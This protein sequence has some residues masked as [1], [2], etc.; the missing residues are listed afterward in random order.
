MKLEL[1][2]VKRHFA[3][4]KA[5]N[6]VGIEDPSDIR[7]TFEDQ[8]P[9]FAQNIA[10]TRA[11]MHE[12]KK[13]NKSQP[14]DIT[15]DEALKL[16]YGIDFKQ[17]LKSLGIYT[18]ADKLVDVGRRFG[19][20]GLNK[21]RFEELMIDHSSFGLP[22]STQDINADYRFI[23]PEV[24]AQ[25]VRIGYQH[26]ALHPN[27]IATT[28]NLAK[29][30]LTMP[31]ILR[32]DAMPTRVNEGAN[33]PMGSLAFGKKEVE[34][35]KIGTGFSVT[36]ELMLEATLDMFFLFLQEV[37]SDMSIGADT[38]AVS[39]LV[40]G[41]Q[42]DLSESAPVI[43][44]TTAATLA[45]L[46]LRRIR[47]RMGRLK[48]TI[49][50]AIMGE[51]DTLIDLNAGNTSR[52]EKTPEQYLGIPVDNWVLPPGQSLFLNARNTMVKL[53]Y[54]GLLTERRRNPQ[55]QE[56]ELFISD[57]IGFAIIRRDARVILDKDVTFASTPFPSYMDIDAR[58]NVAFNE[59]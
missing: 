39:T 55:K 49:T 42:A 46:D 23:I 44:A 4:A 2:R 15:L 53:A 16:T 18:Q 57:W 59:F 31:Q 3:E 52:E 6:G 54:R 58:I 8:L 30:K 21:R 40:N 26:A 11:G 13:G 5:N 14:Y 27:W 47:S 34:V 28:Q 20:E 35:F 10:H 43:G 36:D 9:K 32:G 24:V 29:Q 33:I 25:A 48:N 17:Y 19:L 56:D 41:E 45:P 50:R 7:E 37:G 22:A 51:D 38:L 1:S 12:D